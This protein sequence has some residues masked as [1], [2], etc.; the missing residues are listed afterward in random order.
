M[1]VVVLTLSGIELCFGGAYRTDP[2]FKVQ[3]IVPTGYAFFP[4]R[5]W[6]P[7]ILVG[8]KEPQT[9]ANSGR[10]GTGPGSLLGTKAGWTLQM[11]LANPILP[12]LTFEVN[13]QSN[14]LF[15]EIYDAI[16]YALSTSADF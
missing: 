8:F 15:G 3:E 16:G 11:G 10:G 4:S 6:I 1:V 13:Q 14:V 12:N 5:D 2:D 7:S 9:I